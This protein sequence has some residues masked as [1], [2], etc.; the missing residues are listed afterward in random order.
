MTRLTTQMS[1][2]AHHLVVIS[3][4]FLLYIL[5]YYCCS[6]LYPHFRYFHTSPCGL[7]LVWTSPLVSIRWCILG[8]RLRCA[9]EIRVAEISRVNDPL[10]QIQYLRSD[11]NG[12]R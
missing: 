5:L 4:Y 6:G 3:L 1:L 7:L 8:T 2:L 11:V 12:S 10:R 9:L